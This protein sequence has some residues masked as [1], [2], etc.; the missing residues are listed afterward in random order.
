MNYEVLEKKYESLL[1]QAMEMDENAYLAQKEGKI[2]EAIQGYA[3]ASSLYAQAASA[4]LELSE[5]YPAKERSEVRKS[6][7]RLI[8]ISRD[9]KDDAAA[10]EQSVKQG[11]CT[12]AKPVRADDR[13]APSNFAVAAK[14]ETT[15]N[16]IA[17]LEDAKQLV[18]EEI[19]NPLLYQ[20]VYKRFNL[21]NNGGL[22]LFGPP[23]TGK[24]MMARAIANEANLTF[25]S[26]KCSDIVGKYFGEAEK[27]IKGLY[28]AAR[29]A[30][31]AVV[32]LDEAEALASKRGSHSTVMNRLVPELLAQIDGFEKNEDCTIITIFATNRPQDIDP[33][34]LR[35]GRLP[36]HCYIPLPDAEVRR[37]FLTKLI[38]ACPCKGEIDIE[39]LV[40]KTECFSCA[41]LS[42]LV[43]RG[44][45]RP[46][47]RTI[48]RL[49][50]NEQN[51]EEFLTQDDLI[52][53]LEKL[54][55]SVDPDEIHRLEKWMDKRGMIYPKTA[56]A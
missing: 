41:D 56:T 36:H 20:S 52:Q 32:F 17:G 13:D 50:Q 54:H 6:V 23:G 55:P 22:L 3:L 15:F 26:V 19:I 27:N 43:K 28:D 2:S 7:D 24:T 34:F 14:P 30:R 40:A 46:A 16:D 12:S 35:P 51:P 18:M 29:E 42:N 5:I 45:Q 39:T 53:A 10:L 44:S 11:C 33:G 48:A 37:A 31:N 25:F 1:H 21:V 9:L 8:G 47:N 38:Q 4:L 49:K